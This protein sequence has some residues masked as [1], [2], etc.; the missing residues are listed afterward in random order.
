MCADARSLSICTAADICQLP[1]I[2]GECDGYEVLWYFDTES[3]QCQQFA[4]TG[5]N[6]NANRFESFD[7]C[8]QACYRRSGDEQTPDEPD[9][10]P[11]EPHVEPDEQ[12][13]VDQ[14]H[15][16]PLTVPHKSSVS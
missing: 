7:S 13:H 3:Q 1:K 2:E 6:G 15:K 5:C 14:G 16:P 10:E 9:V 11:D 12:P 8:E 4:Y